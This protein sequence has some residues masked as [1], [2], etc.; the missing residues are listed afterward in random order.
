MLLATTF[1]TATTDDLGAAIINALADAVNGGDQKRIVDTATNALRH[2][3]RS[4][5]QGV[6]SVLKCV[7]E[8]YAETACDVRNLNAVDWAMKAAAHIINVTAMPTP[9]TQYNNIMAAVRRLESAQSA[10]AL[11][12][13]EPAWNFLDHAIK[14]LLEQ[15]DCVMRGKPLPEYV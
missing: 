6:I 2:Q 12:K 13:D 1:P 5:Q 15:A 14:H 3:H 8:E 4:L 11:Y 9:P 7:I 10:F